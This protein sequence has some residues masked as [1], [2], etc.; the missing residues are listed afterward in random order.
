[1]NKLEPGTFVCIPA[2]RDDVGIVRDY[3]G[4]VATVRWLVARTTY[5]EDT[6]DLEILLAPAALE[7]ANQLGINL[8]GVPHS[9]WNEGKYEPSNVMNPY[10]G[11]TIKNIRRGRGTRRTWIYADLIA[12]D[13]R[14][15]ASATIE[16]IVRVL[17]ERLPAGAL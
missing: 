15:L 2:D 13:G 3:S 9:T 7:L 11:A 6:G 16:Y 8:P 4:G 10:E 5:T 17:S 12:A 1:M 14:V